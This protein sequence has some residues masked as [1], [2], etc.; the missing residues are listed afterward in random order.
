[1][2]SKCRGGSKRKAQYGA[3]IEKPD[4]TMDALQAGAGAGATGAS[5]GSA[6]GPMGTGIGFGIGA[7]FGGA[8]SL[9]NAKDKQAAYEEQQR[10]MKRQEAMAKMQADGKNYDANIP[11]FEMG[12]QMPINEGVDEIEGQEHE[13]GGT[14][15]G[16]L[17][18]AQKGETKAGK[19]IYS[20]DIKVS[21]KMAKEYDMPKNFVGKT[22]AEVSKLL[23]TKYGKR[24]NDGLDKAVLDEELDILKEAQEEV[25]QGMMA[26]AMNTIKSINP[27]MASMMQRQGQGQGQGMGMQQGQIQGQPPM[28]EQGMP[29]MKLGG[30]YSNMKEGDPTLAEITE[31]VLYDPVTSADLKRASKGSG[32]RVS[33]DSERRTSEAI[34][35]IAAA[36]QKNYINMLP[37]YGD[38][39]EEEEPITFEEDV[40]ST[41]NLATITG[42]GRPQNNINLTSPAI[43]DLGTLPEDGTASI[44]GA[45]RPNNKG[46][47]DAN[48]GDGKI[49]GNGMLMQNLGNIYDVARGIYSLTKGPKVLPRAT[50][51]L[52][53][54]SLL[55]ASTAVQDVNIGYANAANAV[56]QNAIGASSYLSNRLALA[57]QQGKDVSR[58]RGAYDEANVGITNQARQTNAQILGA[59]QQVNIGQ[60]NLEEQINQ[61]ERDV[62]S[63]MIQKG[64]SNFSEIYGGIG[65]DAAARKVERMALQFLGTQDYNI[66][67]NGD[68]ATITRRDGTG[69]SFQ[70]DRNG[71]RV[72]G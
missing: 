6:F 30:G 9:M 72:G 71:N 55:D 62:A 70:L 42:K 51:N 5:I 21:K 12:G 53:N 50:P 29:M 58:T 61:Q 45:G 41:S 34:N 13:E 10:L 11:T 17:V 27:E 68:I 40:V 24:G 67:W 25:R 20:D 57:A 49:G 18:E 63:N 66:T 36:S 65:R 3:N 33:T 47:V 39:R 8:S 22:M 35:N 7:V 38:I 23:Q 69:G 2:K 19:Y 1:M 14:N 16:N 28:N 44:T 54:P 31:T 46:T 43:A 48:L 64:L 15:M 60:T 59:T 52:V 32:L 56:K 26:N 37:Q 4:A